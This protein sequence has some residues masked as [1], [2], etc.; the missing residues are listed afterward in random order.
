MSGRTPRVAYARLRYSAAFDSECTVERAGVRTHEEAVIPCMIEVRRDYTQYLE[1]Q[2]IQIGAY[3]V[4]VPIQYRL[5]P[6]DYIYERRR[7]LE[8]IHA[9]QPKS[10]Q[11][12]TECWAIEIGNGL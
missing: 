4:I 2:P 1:G 5:L 10:Y 12:R 7:L 9:D 8:V 6:G 11:V 3:L